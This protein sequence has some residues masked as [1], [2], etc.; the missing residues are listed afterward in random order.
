MPKAIN[1]LEKG[2]DILFC[3]NFQDKS[4]SAQTISEHFD[5]PL[6]T[7]YRYL[8]TLKDRGFLARNGVTG[9]RELGFVLFKR[10]TSFAYK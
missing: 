7:N 3:L 10:G 8:E 6:S 5:I 2:L 1:S 4:L 9:N